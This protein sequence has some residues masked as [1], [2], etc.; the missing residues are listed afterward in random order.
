MPSTKT[1]VRLPVQI[2]WLIRRDMAEVLE[3]ERAS[4]EFSW[5]EE[6]FLRCLRQRNCIGTVAESER[7]VIGFMI[8]ERHESGLHILNFAIASH[9]RRQ[10]VGTA[11]IDKLVD[12]LTQQRRNEIVLEVRETN[13][14]A[15]LFFKACR[16]RAVRVLRNQY[17]GATEDAYTMRFRLDEADETPPAILPN[18]ISRYDFA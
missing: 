18:P 16:F 4:F 12:K 7:R 8:Y 10:G 9:A 15:Q 6:E 17:D 1:E 11:M 13:L 5:T 3:I 14:A 2:R